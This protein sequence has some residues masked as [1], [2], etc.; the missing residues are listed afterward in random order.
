MQRK[1][2]KLEGLSGGEIARGEKCEEGKRK[3]M[4]QVGR[5]EGKRTRN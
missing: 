3:E 4:R 1:R 2:N 5:R